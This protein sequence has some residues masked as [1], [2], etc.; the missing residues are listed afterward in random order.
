VQRRRSEVRQTE[1]KDS[2]A[3]KVKEGPSERERQHK[4]FVELRK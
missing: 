1:D 3:N 4:L 2:A